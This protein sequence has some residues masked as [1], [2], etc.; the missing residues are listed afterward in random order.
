MTEKLELQKK[1]IQELGLNA[2]KEYFKID[3][4]KLDKETL[5][6]I[7]NRAKIG[8]Q[9]ER[10]MNVSKRAVEMNYLRVFKLY[11]E[12]KKELKSLIKKSMNHYLPK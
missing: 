11:A 2:L 4:S 3:V 9:F 7:H 10:E 6:H 12:D 8:M 1:E 5:S